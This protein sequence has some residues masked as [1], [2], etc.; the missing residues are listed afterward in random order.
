MKWPYEY[1]IWKKIKI[2]WIFKM[3]KMTTIYKKYF[4]LKDSWVKMEICL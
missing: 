1:D 3:I 4:L 2:G